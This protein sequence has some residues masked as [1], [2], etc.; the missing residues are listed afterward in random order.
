MMLSC[1][2]VLAVVNPPCMTEPPVCVH[3]HY[4]GGVVAKLRLLQAHYVL[5]GGYLKQT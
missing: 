2:F 5:I 1:F 4:K 3:W